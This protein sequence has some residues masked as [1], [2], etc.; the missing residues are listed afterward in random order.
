MVPVRYASRDDRIY[1]LLEWAHRNGAK[2]GDMTV[3]S[4]L[5]LVA[6]T[7]FPSTRNETLSSYVE[8]V[9]RILNLEEQLPPK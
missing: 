4:K 3:P 5:R 8:A 2:C 9:L 7:W 6:R 1:A